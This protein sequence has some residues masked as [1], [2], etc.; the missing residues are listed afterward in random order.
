MNLIKTLESFFRIIYPKK[1]KNRTYYQKCIKNGIG[2]EIGGPSPIFKSNGIL[3]LYS[4]AK[5][6][7]G[8]NFSNNTIWEGALREGISY[9]VA[10]QPGRQYIADGTALNM[11]QDQSYDFVLS[12]HNLEHIANPLKALYEWKRIMKKDAF[13]VLILPHKDRTFDHKR[14]VTDLNHIINDYRNNIGEDDDTH[15]DEIISLHDFSID[16][17]LTDEISFKERL[18][19]NISNR[20]A[21]HHVFNAR[22]IVSLL[23][24][25][26]FRLLDLSLIFHNIVVLADLKVDNS[27][28]SQFLSPVHPAYKDQRYP[29]DFYRK[30]YT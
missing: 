5:R 22:L 18:L 19:N 29:S 28:N 25:V 2:I 23:D 26:G 24:Y 17:S 14:P 20:C 30:Q 11:I 21:H 1:L 27:S 8:C 16:N 3:P 13:L 10:A 9:E 7:D 4:Y 15:F 6:I 12:C